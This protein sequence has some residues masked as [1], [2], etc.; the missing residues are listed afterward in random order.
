MN[1]TLIAS[2]LDRKLF[3]VA[4]IQ[5]VGYWVEK[6]LSEPILMEFVVAYGYANNF[7]KLIV[8][9]KTGDTPYKHWRFPINPLGVAGP[10]D[11]LN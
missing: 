4:D 7:K 11:G 9:Y 2:G 1:Q 3:L 6:V 5:D 10:K 8:Y